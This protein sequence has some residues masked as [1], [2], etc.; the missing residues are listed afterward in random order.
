MSMRPEIR[1]FLEFWLKWAE[2]GGQDNGLF[3][4]DHALCG[5]LKSWYFHV[6]R[7]KG[8]LFVGYCDLR[9]SLVEMFEKDG[10]D[11]RYPFNHDRESFIMSGG[12]HHKNPKRLA[13]VREKLA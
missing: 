8:S 4:R 5:H 2:A 12:A 11:W 1:E 7:E 13:W 3:Y 10:L 9:Y 6:H